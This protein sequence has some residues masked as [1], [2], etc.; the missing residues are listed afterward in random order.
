MAKMGITALYRKPNTSKRHPQHKIYPYLL[1]HLTIERANHV[2]AMDITYVPMQRGF[3]YLA[4][5]MATRPS[6]TPNARGRVVEFPILAPIGEYVIGVVAPFGSLDR[7]HQT[8]LRHRMKTPSASVTL[9][10]LAIVGRARVQLATPSICIV[11][12]SSDR[13]NLSFP[14]IA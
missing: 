14:G 11:N 1:R 13:M 12:D 10:V 5:L 9:P 6:P 2:W 7:P 4:A 8:L 3:V